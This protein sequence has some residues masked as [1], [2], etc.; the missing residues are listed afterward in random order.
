[1]MITLRI[2]PFPFIGVCRRDTQSPSVYPNDVHRH[3]ERGRCR[4][5]AFF[6]K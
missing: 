4:Q 6:F 1:M 3:R 2:G 5:R